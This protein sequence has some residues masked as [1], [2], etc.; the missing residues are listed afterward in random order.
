[1]TPVRRLVSD[2]WD[3]KTIRERLEQLRGQLLQGG[4]PDLIVFTT[5]KDELAA[6]FGP[7]NGS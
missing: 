1:M 5:T 4:M 7:W 6:G 2:R 3:E